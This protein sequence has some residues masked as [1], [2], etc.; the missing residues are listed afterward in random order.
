MKVLRVVLPLAIHVIGGLGK[1]HGAMLAGSFAVRK[2]IHNP[3]L[4]NVRAIGDNRTL[5]NGETP[6]AGSHLDA[7]VSDS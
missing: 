3:D 2:R 1:N 5:G 4:G 6:L 7:M